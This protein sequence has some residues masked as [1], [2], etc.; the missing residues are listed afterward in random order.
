MKILW[1]RYEP[2]HITHLLRGPSSSR[3]LV[4]STPKEK[5]NIKSVLLRAIAIG[6]K[7]FRK[8]RWQHGSMISSQEH[9]T[10][11]VFLPQNKNHRCRKRWV[12]SSATGTSRSWAVMGRDWQQFG[13][14][15]SAA[16]FRT[17]GRPWFWLKTLMM[18]LR[19][20]G[21]NATGKQGLHS[22]WGL[23]LTS[24]GQS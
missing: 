22:N 13:G 10:L 3:A 16:F 19:L 12:P 15:F 6:S 21:I 8:K 1:K 24:F 7:L 23:K 17:C 14:V 4:Q 5:T 20:G 18:N 11:F 2:Q 9:P